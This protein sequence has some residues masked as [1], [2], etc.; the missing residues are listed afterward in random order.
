MAV[1]GLAVA[2]F[3]GLV[4]PGVTIAG[5]VKSSGVGSVTDRLRTFLSTYVWAHALLGEVVTGLQIS[6][7]GVTAQRIPVSQGVAYR[8][9]QSTLGQHRQRLDVEPGVE[10]SSAIP[11]VRYA[12]SGALIS[13][14]QSTRRPDAGF[15]PRRRTIASRKC[16]KIAQDASSARSNVNSSSAL[17]GL[18]VIRRYGSTGS[19]LIAEEVS[20]VVR[21]ARR[22]MPSVSRNCLMTCVPVS[23]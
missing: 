3:L 15:R 16:K 23:P 17:M 18:L 21:T 1:H 9:T 14:P 11:I 7:F 13:V 4:R 8:F 12:A 22:E 2:P 20:P 6:R 19:C 10:A 5:V